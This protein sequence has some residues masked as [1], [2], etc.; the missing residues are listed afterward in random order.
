M[1]V[2]SPPKLIEV[3]DPEVITTIRA[4]FVADAKAEYEKAVDAF[5]GLSLSASTVELAA[6]TRA[7]E[8][9]MYK[10]RALMIEGLISVKPRIR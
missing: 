8:R 4:A 2:Y 3:T 9:S 6:V 10:V 1:R 7:L 5:Q